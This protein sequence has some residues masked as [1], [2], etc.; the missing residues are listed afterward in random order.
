MKPFSVKEVLDIVD[1]VF[2]KGDLDLVLQDAVYRVEK[3]TQSHTLIFRRRRVGMNREAIE[4]YTPSALVTSDCSEEWRT[5]KGCTII[6]VEDVEAA[7]WSFVEYYRQLFS[8]PVIAITGTCGKTT[9]KDMLFHVLNKIHWKVQATRKSLNARTEDLSYLLGMNEETEVGIFETAVGKPGDLHTHLRYLQP[10]IGV[11][12]NIGIYH[13]DGCITLDGY[14][15]AKAEMV[16]GLG[17]ESTL[18]LNADDENIR[19]IHLAYFEGRIVYFGI[20]QQA[21]V[22]AA[23]IH[24][25][26]KGMS[27]DLRIQNVSYPAFV[28]GFGEHQVFNALSAL[29]VLHEMGINIQEATTHL[30][31][32]RTENK[33]L[34]LIPGIQGAVILDDTWSSTPTSIEAA[35]KVLK[36]L[37]KNSKKVAV[38]AE[39][40]RLGDYSLFY[41]QRVGEMIADAEVNILITIG[42]MAKEITKQ[43]CLKGWKG[44]VFSFENEKGIYGRM[45]Q[46]LDQETMILFKFSSTY[47]ELISLKN[48]IIE[49]EGDLKLQNKKINSLR[50]DEMKKIWVLYQKG[51]LLKDELYQLYASEAINLGAEIIFFPNES[52][53]W[54]TKTIKGYVYDEVKCHKKQSSFPNNIIVVDDKLIEEVNP[55]WR[56]LIIPFPIEGYLVKDKWAIY[57][58]LQNG[59][60]HNE[61]IPSEKI[62]SSGH[63]F[64]MLKEYRK[65]VIKPT[66]GV[67]QYVIEQKGNRYFVIGGE[68]TIEKSRGEL[69][70]FVIELQK[71]EQHI[72]QPHLLCRTKDG[73]VFDFKV[74]LQ[75]DE[76]NQWEIKKIVPRFYLRNHPYLAN[77]DIDFF[78]KYCFPFNSVVTKQNL[79]TF[80]LQFLQKLDEVYKEIGE[81]S[82]YVK[83][84]DLQKVWVDEIQWKVNEADF[85]R[86]HLK[87]ALLFSE[88]K[89]AIE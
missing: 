33:H 46:F 85:V 13:L 24:Y 3:I 86:K 71:Q 73:E 64:R 66:V 50:G 5:I 75:K 6:T 54:E 49:S 48:R 17:K 7:F 26:K 62:K 22:R 60:F 20:D 78:L 36:E 47:K 32:F 53:N 81:L 42:A 11:I 29:A 43:A 39:I 83:L 1:G 69:R 76:H 15:Q 67:N 87:E 52:V 12:T 58:R 18:I 25:G 34:E 63:F 9:T 82:L 65:L 88:K 30:A 51:K 79:H 72:V 4:K 59:E 41:H 80:C 16:D 38:I 61:L 44:E 77:G 45:V 23:N 40:K 14:I 89:G 55:Q 2:E 70:Q 31:T 68:K 74:S 37:G 27:F 84:D 56:K 8:I 35:L 28:P 10:T 19:K 21:E 57:E